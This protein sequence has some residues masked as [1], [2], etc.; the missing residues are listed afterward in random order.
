MAVISS[1][2]KAGNQTEK[3]PRH[4][5]V[6]MPLAEECSSRGQFSR[7]QRG[8]AGSLLRGSLMAPGMGGVFSPTT[9]SSVCIRFLRELLLALDEAFLLEAPRVINR[10]PGVAQGCNEHLGDGGAPHTLPT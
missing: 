5:T 7:S 6:L 9:G 1:N 4:H 10:E 2:Y 3:S 8:F